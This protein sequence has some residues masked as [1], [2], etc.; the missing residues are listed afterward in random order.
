VIISHTPELRG[1]ELDSCRKKGIEG[2]SMQSQ[3]KMFGFKKG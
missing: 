3:E 1:E 2:F